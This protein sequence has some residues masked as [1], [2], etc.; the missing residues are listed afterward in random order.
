MVGEPKP[1]VTVAVTCVRALSQLPVAAAIKKLVVEVTVGDVSIKFGPEVEDAKSVP[2]V[3]ALYKRISVPATPPIC[4]VN[5]TVPVPQREALGAFTTGMLGVPVTDTVTGTRALSP[6]VLAEATKKVVV[7]ET[8]GVIKLKFGPEVAVANNVPPV[9]AL[10]KRISVPAGVFIVAIKFAAPFPQTEILVMV[11]VGPAGATP[12]V[13]VT[14]VR[15]PSQVPL[16]AAI[17]KSVVAETEG[18]V[19]LKFGPAVV[20]PKSVPPVAALYKRISVPAGAPLVA[21]KV[22]V[23]VEQ[24]L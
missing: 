14:L 4:A 5:T 20:E 1:A 19:T 16:A 21:I 6:Q 2:P 7:E 8:F 12:T 18:V 13:T 24:R 23:P 11:T 10:Y 9:T 22:A 17:Q 15:G 3:T